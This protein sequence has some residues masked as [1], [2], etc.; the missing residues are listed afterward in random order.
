MWAA[1]DWLGFNALSVS[2]CV[3]TCTAMYTQRPEQGV[4]ALEQKSGRPVSQHV[5]AGNQTQV[6]CESS[7][8]LSCRAIPRLGLDR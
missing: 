4:C 1:G 6:L 2:A 3:C 5:G 8:Y 7:R